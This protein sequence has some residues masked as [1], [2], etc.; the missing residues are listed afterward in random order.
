MAGFLLATFYTTMVAAGL[1]VEFLFQGLGLTPTERNAKVEMASI[2][3]NYTTVLNVIFLAVLGAL[4]LGATSPDPGGH[5]F[6]MTVAVSPELVGSRRVRMRGTEV[7]K[8]R[9]QVGMRTDPVI[10]DSPLR[11]E[12]PRPV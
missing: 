11:Q 7:R 4:G 5:R 9:E 12:R 8:V 2:H 6:V 10:R 3:L 1:I